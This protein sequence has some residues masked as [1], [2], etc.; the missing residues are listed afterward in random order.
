[1][2]VPAALHPPP[3]PPFSSRA[4][5][6]A[7]RL[8]LPPVTTFPFNEAR[9]SAESRILDLVC[10]GESDGNRE[11]ARS[12]APVTKGAAMEVPERLA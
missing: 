11:A 12:A 4:P 1:M 6:A 10:A 7:A 9:G 3:P 2:S 5:R 8:S